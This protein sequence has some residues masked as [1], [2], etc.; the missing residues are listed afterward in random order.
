MGTLTIKDLSHLPPPSHGWHVMVVVVVEEVVVEKMHLTAS[1][2]ALG[3]SCKLWF[4]QMSDTAILLPAAPLW[5]FTCLVN[6]FSTP[7]SQE[8]VMQNGLGGAR[9]GAGTPG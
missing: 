7:R 9:A 1:V 3:D 4:H 2:C 8:G 5:D 6:I